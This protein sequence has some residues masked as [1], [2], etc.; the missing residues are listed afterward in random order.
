MSEDF[1]K[2]KR[3]QITL[4]LPWELK[5]LIHREAKNKGM[6]FNSYILSVICRGLQVKQK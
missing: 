3:T 4:R 1:E 6:S 5:E 2:E